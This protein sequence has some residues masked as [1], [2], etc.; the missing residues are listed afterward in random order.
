[1]DVEHPTPMEELE[2]V[3][4]ALSWPVKVSVDFTATNKA[5]LIVLLREFTDLFT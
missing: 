5:N 2:V 3:L 1:M 4:L